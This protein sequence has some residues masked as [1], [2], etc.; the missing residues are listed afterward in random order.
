MPL[1]LVGDLISM[2]RPQTRQ[3]LQGG[4]QVFDSG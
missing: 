3:S 4:R 1:V 2:R